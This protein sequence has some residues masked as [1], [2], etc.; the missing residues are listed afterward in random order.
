MIKYA[1]L[2]KK[3]HRFDSWFRSSED[4]ETL[5]ASG[6]LVCAVCG[7]AGVTKALMTPGV[8]AAPEP[9]PDAGRPTAAPP[10]PPGA[11]PLSAPASPS[12]QALAALRRRVEANAENVGRTFAA[13]ARRIH[14]G[15]A[16]GRPIYGE[17][18]LAEA[19]KLVED[20]IPVIPLPW[21]NRKTS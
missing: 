20:D 16:D 5:S 2:C 15:E 3:G 18:S 6:H 17:A 14:N 13:E 8:S 11:G 12:E 21:R 7:E 19:K 9:K 4:F 1:L 10:S